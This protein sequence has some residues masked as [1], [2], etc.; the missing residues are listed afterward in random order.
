MER[1]VDNI[2]RF[3]CVCSLAPCY[4]SECEGGER[5]AE[6]RL[7]VRGTA[8]GTSCQSSTNG[9]FKCRISTIVTTLQDFTLFISMHPLEFSLNHQPPLPLQAPCSSALFSPSRC[10]W[11]M[12]FRQQQKK[13]FCDIRAVLSLFRFN[14]WLVS[15]NIYLFLRLSCVSVVSYIYVISFLYCLLFALY[16]LLD[17]LLYFV[18]S[19]AVYIFL[20]S[21]LHFL[22]IVHLQTLLSL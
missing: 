18:F 22:F 8:S 10:G 14:K 17:V 20:L 2:D 11:F 13:Q 6:R 4:C 19:L 1:K 16:Y 21:L 5:Q 7:T 3:V 9:M 15:P 12:E